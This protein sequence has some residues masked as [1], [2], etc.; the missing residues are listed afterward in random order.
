[1][2]D[3]YA[4]PCICF[5][6]VSL[7]WF[8]NNSASIWSPI[9]FRSQLL[10]QQFC[11]SCVHMHSRSHLLSSDFAL[12]FSEKT[13]ATRGR[14]DVAAQL[15]VLPAFTQW[16]RLHHCC[17]LQCTSGP[18]VDMT[19]KGNDITSKLKNCL[20]I[21]SHSHERDL[22]FSLCACVT[23]STVRFYF[24]RPEGRW[25]SMVHKGKRLLWETGW[26]ENAKWLHQWKVLY[27]FLF[28]SLLE[29][30]NVLRL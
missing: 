12:C 27:F 25:K 2:G 28:T 11:T 7:I 29:L 24:L 26:T 20:N 4:P 10:D 19:S 3:L 6:Y 30:N 8:Y 22:L 15:S 16:P 18:S 21:V 23:P 14:S 5:Y 1:M 9:F 13:T 17:C